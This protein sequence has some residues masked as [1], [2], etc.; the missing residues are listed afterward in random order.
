MIA[1]LIVTYNRK[2]LLRECLD[3]V[4]SQTTPPDRVY[5]V[6]NAS[7]DGTPEML[8]DLYSQSE[9]VV[10][11]ACWE[12]RQFKTSP[13]PMAYYRLRNNTGASG[14]FNFGM[15]M[16]Y[17]DGADWIWVMDDDTIPYRDALEQLVSTPRFARS[18]TG[19]LASVPRWS[20]G[21]IHVMNVHGH[22]V[23]YSFLN[24]NFDHRCI[25]AS[26]CSFVGVMISRTAIET[27][28]F[29][30]KDFFIWSDDTEYTYRI[31]EKGGLPSFYVFGS[32]VLHKTAHNRGAGIQDLCDSNWV[33]YWYGLR[34]KVVLTRMRA[35]GFRKSVMSACMLAVVLS[36][37][38]LRNKRLSTIHKAK[39]VLNI[40]RGLA[41]FPKIETVELQQGGVGKKARLVEAHGFWTL[42]IGL[43]YIAKQ[44]GEFYD[45]LLV[46]SEPFEP[47]ANIEC[48][49]EYAKKLWKFD[50]ITIVRD[51]L[52]A[53][54]KVNEKSLVRQLL[55]SYACVLSSSV[56]SIT[57]RLVHENDI[58]AE[59]VVCCADG[60]GF[61]AHRDFSSS[62]HAPVGT[63]VYL[64]YSPKLDVSC[65]KK[66]IRS[67]VPIEKEDLLPSLWG[68]RN[69]VDLSCVE[70]SDEFVI[71]FAGYLWKTH[72]G[73][74]WDME[75]EVHQSA[76]ESLLA[77]NVKVL[78]RDHFRNPRPFYDAIKDRVNGCGSHFLKYPPSL[79]PELDD[80]PA[81]P[82]AVLGVFSTALLTFA[83]V[84]GIP[85]YTFAA[86]E[87]LARIPDRRSG[88]AEND[89]RLLRLIKDLLPDMSEFVRLRREK[90]RAG[91]AAS[92]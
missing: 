83:N 11:G 15:K 65:A 78:F 70:P 53:S 61:F 5:L 26:N 13:V 43:S 37:Q 24:D 84:Y 12:C 50:R 28:G 21:N 9:D 41:F 79:V 54:G 73:V 17:A 33:K 55:P 75:C 66:H 76:V 47:Q 25:P 42:A 19:F 82:C 20:D 90:E 14:G 63:A 85:A 45:H 22:P 49:V 7:S 71:L 35:R 36:V 30:I 91:G 59:E 40:L 31:T 57:N 48:L 27:V 74:P 23:N 29:P 6:D 64:N 72:G 8:C 77:T 58:E 34:N 38:V 16:A 52:A 60:L 46:T 39:I 32:N 10:E 69:P 86:D 4:F 87:F 3:A 67:L 92:L 68:L 51:Y 44:S 81:K 2:E 88:F 56:K 89:K 1:V 80:L 18:N 62:R